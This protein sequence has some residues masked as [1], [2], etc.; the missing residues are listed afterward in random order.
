MLTEFEIW[1]QTVYNHIENCGYQIEISPTSTDENK[2]IQIDFDSENIIA[3]IT[4]W[5]TWNSYECSLQILEVDSGL[6]LLN[7]YLEII[8]N[9]EFNKALHPFFTILG[10]EVV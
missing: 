2:S 5:R 6:T 9:V 4:L 10:V 3:R 8:S 7:Q 1:F